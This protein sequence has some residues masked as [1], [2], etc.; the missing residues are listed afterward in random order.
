[1][2]SSE[3][4]IG[5]DFQVLPSTHLVWTVIIW[6]CTWQCMY[7]MNLYRVILFKKGSVNKVFFKYD[8]LLEY[9]LSIAEGIMMVT[10]IGLLQE[11]FQKLKKSLD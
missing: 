7:F 8:L 3:I 6:Q 2:Q 10:F 4:Q 9:L 1:M 11:Y 5:L